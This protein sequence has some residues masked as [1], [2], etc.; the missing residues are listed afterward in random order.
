MLSSSKAGS[1]FGRPV[2]KVKKTFSDQERRWLIIFS[3]CLILL[4]A[5]PYLLASD[6]SADGFT[7]FLL[8]VEDGN[9]YIAKML[10]G[11]Q[12]DWL[13]R[14]PYTAAEQGGAL[15]YLP[16]I[17]LGKVLGPGAQHGALVLAFHIF[18]SASVLALCF[19]IY[20]FLAFFIPDVKLRRLGL[21]LITLGGGLG[22]LLLFLGIPNLLGSIPLD[23]YSPEAFGF[24]AIFSLPHLVLARALLLWGL[25]SYLR[26]LEGNAGAAIWQTMALWAALALTHLITAVLGLVLISAHFGF[27]FL[28]SYFVKKK[29][30]LR[31]QIPSI[32]WPLLGAFPVLAYNAW[33][34]WQDAYLRAWAAQNQ[35]LSPHP[36]HYLIAYGLYLPFAYLGLRRL[37]GKQ[38]LS[39]SFLLVWSVLLPVLLYAPVGLQRRLSEGALVLLVV[40]A[41]SAFAGAAKKDRLDRRQ[42]WMFALAL[43]TTLTLL[44][45]SLQAARDLRPPV[46]RPESEIRA[47]A[48]L[49]EV[50]DVGDVVL[51]SYETGNALPAW[52]PVRVVAGHGPESVDLERLLPRIQA[53][54]Q[55]RTSDDTRLEFFL[56]YDVDYVFWGSN[57]QRLGSWL[58]GQEDYLGLV[59]DI[60]EHEIYR[61]LEEAVR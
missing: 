25:L 2:N 52:A 54:Y 39:A 15:I 47:F 17:L 5:F 49:R 42:L 10:S 37:L 36:L 3:V 59:A 11:A 20:E 44:L 50:I 46:F 18:R 34:F 1:R 55:G 38:W 61:V 16:Y 45:G 29:I 35:I 60:G 30:D 9:S 41:L 32:A 21:T 33:A 6:Q 8:G 12:G 14:S 31:R 56:R 7:G 51:T 48:E 22:W 58:P 27:L 4:T 19:A 23:F 24:L 13:F 40:L 26:T 53:I 57:E 28:R 43:P